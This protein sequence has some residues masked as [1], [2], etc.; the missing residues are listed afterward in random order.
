MSTEFANFIGVWEKKRGQERLPGFDL[1]NWKIGIAIYWHRGDRMSRFSGRGEQELCFGHSKSEMHI[2]NSDRDVK[3]VVGYL[4][5]EFRIPF[6]NILSI[7][8]HSTTVFPFGPL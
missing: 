3:K 1:S 4:N 5:L 2:R 8:F 7:K 6:S